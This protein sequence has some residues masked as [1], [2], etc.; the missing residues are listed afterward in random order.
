MTD[1]PAIAAYC[2]R[3][4]PAQKTILD[5]LD[6]VGD[7]LP[8]LGQS[9]AL[10]ALSALALHR[11]VLFDHVIGKAPAGAHRGQA[12]AS[13]LLFQPAKWMGPVEGWLPRMDHAFPGWI[14]D[15]L[16]P[17]E[18]GLCGWDVLLAKSLSCSMPVQGDPAMDD[19][20]LLARVA[21]MI[22]RR[23]PEI[24]NLPHRLMPGISNAQ[25]WAWFWVA[26]TMRNSRRGRMAVILLDDGNAR[27]DEA[28]Q[29]AG[30]PNRSFQ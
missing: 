1:H 20:A 22:E 5:L 14:D 8:T 27:I 26:I 2:A 7:D 12:I 6:A 10:A 11:N 4:C 16:T 19:H 28:A 3:N 18:D 21:E 9:V 15:L 23:H 13:A 17:G 29:A 25:A 24:F 30:R